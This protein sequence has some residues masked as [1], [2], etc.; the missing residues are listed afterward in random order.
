MPGDLRGTG[1]EWTLRSIAFNVHGERRRGWVL[2]GK[3][4]APRASRIRGAE[5]DDDRK[6][7]YACGGSPKVACRNLARAEVPT[8]QQDHSDCTNQD[9]RVHQVPMHVRRSG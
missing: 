8:S 6:G 9:V 7:E 3:A 5:R 4:F 2:D 1:E